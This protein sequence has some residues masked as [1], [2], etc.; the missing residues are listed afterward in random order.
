MA[1]REQLIDA[2]YDWYRNECST[3][4]SEIEWLVN[5][6][7]DNDK[8]NENVMEVLISTFER[9]LRTENGLSVEDVKEYFLNT[10]N[11]DY[12]EEPYISYTGQDWIEL[13]NEY[14]LER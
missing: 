2:Y 11:P 10:G 14:D 8:E 3:P 4:Y 9:S 5:V 13:A 12:E 7:L 6:A 1:N